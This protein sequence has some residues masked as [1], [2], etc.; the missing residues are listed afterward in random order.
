MKLRKVVE[1]LP[2]LQKLSAAEL[3]L[4]RL[5]WVRKLI[6]KLE[7]EIAFFNEERRKILEKYKD[8]G[9][10]RP[11]AVKDA[12]REIE[13]LLNVDVEVDFQIAEISDEEEVKLSN[14]DVEALEG[15]VKILFTEDEDERSD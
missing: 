12:N 2:S 13:D 4:K 1:A 10:M 14:N 7:A 3:S 6:R 15:F 5:Y 8:G 11:E 9:K